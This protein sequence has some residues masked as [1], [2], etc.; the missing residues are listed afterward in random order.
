MRVLVAEDDKALSRRLKADLA[1]AGFAVDIS[2]SGVD[3]EFMG[4]EIPYD[5]VV[6]DLGLPGRG[7]LEVLKNWRAAGNRVPVIF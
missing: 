5:A 2:E 7:G 6:L 3:A 1:G 4:T